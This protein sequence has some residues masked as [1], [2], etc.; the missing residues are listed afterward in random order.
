MSSSWLQQGRVFSTGCSLTAKTY[1]RTQIH[2]NT[3]R[4]THTYT[5]TETHTHTH[6]NRITHTHIQKTE[7]HIHTYR[8][9]HTHRHT[10]AETE[11]HTHTDTHTYKPTH[12]HTENHSLSRCRLFLAPYMWSGALPLRAIT[13]IK[14]VNHRWHTEIKVHNMLREV[15]SM[16]LATSEADL[17]LI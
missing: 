14:T 12:T 17:W 3:Q 2:W 11:T 9:K 1:T 4:H 8:N 5:H 7:S 15:S 10:K 16:C 13:V 6:R